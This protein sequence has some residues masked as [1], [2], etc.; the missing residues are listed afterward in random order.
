MCSYLTLIGINQ[1]S[2]IP[3]L[4][5]S[6]PPQQCL[7]VT[8][9][10]YPILGRFPKNWFLNIIIHHFSRLPFSILSFILSQFSPTTTDHQILA[11]LWGCVVLSFSLSRVSSSPSPPPSFNHLPVYLSSYISISFFFSVFNYVLVPHR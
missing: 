6:S 1:I 10:K 8:K 7:D 11:I 4:P 2:S 5:P 3:P 9:H